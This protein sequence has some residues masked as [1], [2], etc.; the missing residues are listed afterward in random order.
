MCI[1]GNEGVILNGN[2]GGYA[3]Y[4]RLPAKMAFP[5]PDG[6]DSESVGPLL[7]GGITVYAPLRKYLK[8][9][10]MRVAVVGIGGLG[11]MAIRFAHAMGAEVVAISTSKSK[12][13]EAINE[14]GADKFVIS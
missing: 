9:P 4:I 2:Y 13:K 14:H 6:L 10:G 8:H 5:I 11:H 12:E 3:N 7:C 1:K